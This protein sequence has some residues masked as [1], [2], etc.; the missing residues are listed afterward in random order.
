[1]VESASVAARFLD[2]LSIRPYN[3]RVT[4]LGRVECYVD[5]LVFDRA[6]RVL[7]HEGATFHNEDG[8]V[9]VEARLDGVDADDALTAWRAA[10]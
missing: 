4:E 6:R 1:M 10:S 3:L 9:Y 5:P 2:S 8:F 7:L